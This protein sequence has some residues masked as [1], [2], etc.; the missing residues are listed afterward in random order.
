MKPNGIIGTADGKF[1]FVADAGG[2]KTYRYRIAAAGKLTDRQLAAPEGS[3]GMTL[4]ESGNLYL[5]RRN[6]VVYSPAGK[7]IATIEVPES[8]ANVTFGGKERRTL[9]ITA[10]KSLYSLEM[11]VRGQ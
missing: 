4:D 1:L 8:P 6:V 5:T 3:D 9:F 2:G 11:A 10:R 7:K